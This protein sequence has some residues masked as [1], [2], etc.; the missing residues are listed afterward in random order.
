MDI[1]RWFLG[2][3]ELAPSVVSLGG[4][5]GYEDDAETP[6]TQIVFQGYE[7]APL[8]FEVRGLPESKDAKNMDKYKGA[9]VGC[10]IECEGG[11]VTVP[12]YSGAAAYDKDG[13]E[14]K[15]WSGAENHFANFIKAVHSRRVEDLHAD[16][17]EGHLSSALCHTGNISY[18]LG[19]KKSP[20]EIKQTLKD[21]KG[22]AE[23][24]ARMAE[25]LGKNEVDITND[26][27][28]LGVPLKMDPK[29]EKFI[30]NK[31]ADALLTRNYRAPYIVPE[32][33]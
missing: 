33:V 9:S 14:L 26:K 25:H 15:K 17:L 5:L 16:I 1:C 22:M 23:A 32:N 28:T 30:G 29:T 7:K 8:I 18:R 21:T 10:V 3:M 24:F 2:E 19:A 4:R 27:V 20:D 13:K 31:S 6:N 12:N 11:Y